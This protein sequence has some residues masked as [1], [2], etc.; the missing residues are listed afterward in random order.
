MGEAT[1][2]ADQEI[3]AAQSKAEEAAQSAKNCI[4]VVDQW[5]MGKVFGRLFTSFFDNALKPV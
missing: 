5:T 1:E 2:K 4:G 3:A